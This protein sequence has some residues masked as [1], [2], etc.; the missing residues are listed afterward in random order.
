[1][2]VYIG[3]NGADPQSGI[4]VYNNWIEDCGDAIE[5]NN[6]TG[7]GAITDIGIF[8]NVAVNCEKG[9]LAAVQGPAYTATYRLVNNTFYNMSVL[10]IGD[11]G[12]RNTR[13]GCVWR[14]NIVVVSDAGAYVASYHDYRAGGIEI[15]HNLYYSLS[16]SYN[17]VHTYGTGY[18]IDQD[19]R[20]FGSGDY[21]LAPDSPARDA[22]S[23]TSAPATDFLGNSRALAD[24]VDIGAFAYVAPQPVATPPASEEAMTG[25]SG[26]LVSG[27][28]VALLVVMFLMRALA[29]YLSI[30]PSQITL[31]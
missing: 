24:R 23:V 20:F 4:E 14:N 1:V 25:V 7:T 8:N 30:G 22:G 2:G 21:R 28:V 18:V 13:T 9:F 27:I 29:A 10:G 19:P 26:R 5:I 15:D 6:E 17:A 3:G 31:R 16:R 12:N 11:S